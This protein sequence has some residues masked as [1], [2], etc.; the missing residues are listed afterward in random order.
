MPERFGYAFGVFMRSLRTL[1]IAFA[2]ALTAASLLGQGQFALAQSVDDAE[3]DAEGAGE[4]AEVAAGLVDEAVAARGEIE[5]ELVES[6]GRINDLSAELS[7]VSAGL[8]KLQEQISFADTELVAIASDLEVQAVDAYMTALGSPGVS[9]VN[10]GSVEEAMVAGL[11]VEDVLSAGQ[12]KVD[13]LVVKKRGLEDLRA[14]Y[15]TTQQEV[16]DLKAEVDAEMLK[17]ERLFEEADSAVAESIREANAADAEYRAALSSVDAAHAR[18]AE[19]RRQEDRKTTSTTSPAPGTTSP[20]TTLP[21]ATTSTTSGGGGGGW[22]FPPAVEQWR[23]LVQQHFPANRVDEALRIIQCESGG[24]PNALNPYSGAAGL[25]QFLPSTWASTAPKAGYPDA[26]VF[27]PTA[28]TASAAW[29]ANRYQ[30]LGQYYW[31][32]WSCRRFL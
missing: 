26:S 31:R 8:D 4:R 21:A 2:L 29:L 16:A 32:A 23:G 22:T 30:E 14:D 17:L 11:V 25:F 19:R 24:D 9:F 7:T 27:D 18:E 5:L 10:S 12:E 20:T 1:S 28:N 13:E 3:S 15:L 6:I